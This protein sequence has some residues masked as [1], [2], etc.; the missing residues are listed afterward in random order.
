MTA[1][2]R[3]DCKAVQCEDEMQCAACGLAW[4]VGDSEPPE[5]RNGQP[6]GAVK[7]RYVDPLFRPADDPRPWG[8]AGRGAAEALGRQ[9]AGQL[10][11]RAVAA[12]ARNERT[13]GRFRVVLEDT[14]TG[15]HGVGYGA[16]VRDAT[17]S[18]NVD[19]ARRANR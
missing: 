13:G 19:M 3:Y 5:C 1:N 18:A 15:R 8:A 7:R 2:K 14:E 12:A 17:A 9:L 4:D 16:T 11:D 6:P 10:D